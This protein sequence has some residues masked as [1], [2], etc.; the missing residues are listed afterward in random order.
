MISIKTSEQIE[1]IRTAS[2]VLAQ[3]L[4][5]LKQMIKPGVNCLE[6]DQ[7]FQDFITSKNCQSN[8]KGYHG[9]PKTICISINEQ[10]VHGI[11]QN[12]VLQNG[13][14]VSID[15]GCTYQGW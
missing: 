2:K 11:P 12:R 8:F 10:L 14:I 7:V 13:D 9:F 1:K 3:G 4:E 5:I 6:L 15:A